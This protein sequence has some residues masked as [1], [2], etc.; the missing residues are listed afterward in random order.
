MIGGLSNTTLALKPDDST[1]QERLQIRPSVD[2]IA[3][4]INQQPQWRVLEASPTIE[5][6]KTLYRFKLLN[7]ERGSVK[8]F[9]VDPNDPLFK[10]LHLGTP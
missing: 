8:V 3:R 7:K 5:N 6:E 10:T 2:D 4:Q 9:I 1:L